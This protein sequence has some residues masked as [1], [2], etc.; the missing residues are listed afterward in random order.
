MWFCSQLQKS[1]NKVAVFVWSLEEL[2]A[3]LHV[4]K[5]I[6]CQACTITKP[7]SQQT[8]NPFMKTL[9]S[10]YNGPLKVPTFWMSQWRLDLRISSSRDIKTIEN[11]PGVLKKPCLI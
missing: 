5:V 4:V 1:K 11:I 10:G 2:R 6:T 8:T 3:G 9:F 7:L